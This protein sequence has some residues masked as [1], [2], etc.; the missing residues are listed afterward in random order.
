MEGRVTLEDLKSASRV[1][2]VNSVRE[3]WPAEVHIA[4]TAATTPIAAST[5]TPTA[6][7]RSQR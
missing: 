1:W 7:K 4:N 5:A 6:A 3:W 2:I